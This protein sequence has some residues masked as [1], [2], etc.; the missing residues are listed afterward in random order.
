MESIFCE[1]MDWVFLT[2][3]LNADFTWASGLFID[4]ER[5]DSDP[6]DTKNDILID[7]GW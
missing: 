5:A 3:E 4:S 2:P 7:F 1:E 6:E